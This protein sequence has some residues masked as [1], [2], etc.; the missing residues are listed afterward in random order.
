[1]GCSLE[2]PIGTESQ[3]IQIQLIVIDLH[4]QVSTRGHKKQDR[5]SN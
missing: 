5:V 3:H 4:E 1:M 2:D